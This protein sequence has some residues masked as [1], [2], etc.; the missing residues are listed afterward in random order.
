MIRLIVS[1]IDGTLLP[2]G[3]TR[4][5]ER[6]FPLIDRLRA[7]G[8]LFCPASGR[9]YHSLRG[10]FGPAGDKLTYLC[11][12]G[13]ILYGPGREEDA[14]VLGKTPMDRGEA[15]ALS[16]AIL[17]LPECQL[18][19]SGANVSYLCQCPQNYVDYMGGFKG[20]RVAVLEDMA[21]I[22][23]DIIKV[24]AYCPQGTAGPAVLLGPRWGKTFRM[25]A[26]GPDWLDFTLAD[27]GTGLAQLCQA[28]GVEASEVMAF[29]DNWNDAAMLAMAGESWLMA[30]ADPALLERFPRHCTSVEDTLEAFLA[31][32]ER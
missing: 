28:L 21:E 31:E 2:Y 27:K 12:N 7:R 26:A 22:G 19:V 1:D 20:N 10:L 32:L 11:E 16:R 14:P 25:A 23:E 17:A 29:G 5:R 8:I 18:L 9:Q 30:G 13:A 24:S 15:L 6:L 3:E 4:L